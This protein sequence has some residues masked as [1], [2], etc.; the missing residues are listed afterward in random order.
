V[1]TYTI[2]PCFPAAR[3]PNRQS[4]SSTIEFALVFPLF[5]AVFYA[6]AAYSLVMALE[7]SLTYAA[8]EG[9]RAAVAVDPTDFNNEGDYVNA[10]R[11]RSCVVAT[12]RAGWLSEPPACASEV[13]ADAGDPDTRTVTLT[14]TY[15]YAASPLVPVI[16]V[17]LI[18]EIP[19]VPD[20]LVVRAVGRI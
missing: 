13:A 9:A 15:P 14:L 8:A 4:G 19:A 6:I 7:Q 3:D 17:P 18:G 1:S 11:N 20:E 5:F 10:I 2:K 16:D 12:E